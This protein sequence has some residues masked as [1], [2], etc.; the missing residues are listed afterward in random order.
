VSKPF[1]DR[2]DETQRSA[3]TYHEL[4]HCSRNDKEQWVI[5]RHDLEEFRAVVKHFGLWSPAVSGMY[6]Q[7]KLWDAHAGVRL[8]K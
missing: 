7:M 5:V 1:W 3:L 4:L 2:L 6:E 8:V